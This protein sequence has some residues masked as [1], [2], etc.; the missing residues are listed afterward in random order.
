MF[1]HVELWV[2]NVRNEVRI[3]HIL[4]SFCTNLFVKG[5][6]LF[7]FPDFLYKIG[8]L[9]ASKNGITRKKGKILIPIWGDKGREGCQKIK[10]LGGNHLFMD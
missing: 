10:K 7:F 5:L 9:G 6:D 1:Y 3:K 2:K 8:S 4:H